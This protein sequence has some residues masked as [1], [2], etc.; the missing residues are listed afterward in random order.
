MRVP[1]GIPLWVATAVIGRV[2]GVFG[3][4][5]IADGAAALE[6]VGSRL[7]YIQVD[8][9]DANN[10]LRPDSASLSRANGAPLTRELKGKGRGRVLFGCREEHC[11]AGTWYE[12]VS[13]TCKPRCHSCDAGQYMTNNDHGFTSCFKCGKGQ[14][15]PDATT[16][17][18]ECKPGKFQNLDA[19]T[20]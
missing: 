7:K 15:A 8:G 17:C 12:E 4:L 3:S 9:K 16:N 10:F 20:E 14:A 19:A 1:V 11:G 6:E 2:F 5:S 13:W 18:K